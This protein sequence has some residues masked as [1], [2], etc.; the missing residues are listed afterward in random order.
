ME[1]TSTSG[2]NGL[3]VQLEPFQ[4]ATAAMGELFGQVP[5]STPSAT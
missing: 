5:V 1:T 2:G 3:T 4:W